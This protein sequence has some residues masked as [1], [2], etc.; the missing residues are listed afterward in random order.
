MKSSLVA[1]S[2]TVVAGALGHSGTV[3]ADDITID[4]H[5]FTSQVSRSEVRAALDAFRSSGLNPWAQNFDQLKGLTSSRTRAEVTAEYL[6]ERDAVSAMNGEDS[7]SQ[8]LAQMRS[9]TSAP[10]YQAGRAP[11]NKQR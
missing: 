2:F 3:R 7:G 10:V 6:R 4:Q 11:A 5:P 8:Y 1:L 9:A